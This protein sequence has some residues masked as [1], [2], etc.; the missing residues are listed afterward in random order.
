MFP[1]E[2]S[3]IQSVC[4]YPE[5]GHPP[6]FVNISPTVVIIDTLLER[7]SQVLQYNMETQKFNFL[8]K[9]V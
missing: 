8:L 2:D 7:F 5:K 4:P 9:K 6:I 3:K 1:Y